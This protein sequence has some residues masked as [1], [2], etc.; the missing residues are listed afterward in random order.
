MQLAEFLCCESGS[1]RNG[2]RPKKKINPFPCVITWLWWGMGVRYPSRHAI[3]FNL[4]I[5]KITICFFNA[6]FINKII[7]SP[8]ICAKYIYLFIS[9][10]SYKYVQ[11]F[12]CFRTHI[13]IHAHRYIARYFGPIKWKWPMINFGK[14]PKECVIII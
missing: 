5:A 7:V 13:H 3:N 11:E 6:I 10:S 9:F 8:R 2:T 12:C 1:H 4:I 14:V